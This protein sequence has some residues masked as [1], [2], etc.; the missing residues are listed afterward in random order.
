MSVGFFSRILRMFKPLPK[1]TGFE[2]G[3]RKS[4]T[5]DTAALNEKAKV[6]LLSRHLVTATRENTYLQKERET[7]IKYI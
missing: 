7:R 6:Y 4:W 1:S 5:Q 3:R 2:V